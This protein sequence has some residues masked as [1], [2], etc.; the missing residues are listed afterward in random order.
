MVVRKIKVLKKGAKE[1]PKKKKCVYRRGWRLKVQKYRKCLNRKTSE[2]KVS[3]C[4][5]N[6]CI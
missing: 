5:V 1:F 4:N 6:R 3:P 2:Q